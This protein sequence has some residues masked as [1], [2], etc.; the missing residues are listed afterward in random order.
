M[1]FST[2]ARVLENEF[3]DRRRII[4]TVGVVL[5]PLLNDEFHGTSQP[6]IAFL[7]HDRILFE[8][9]HFVRVAAHVQQRNLRIGQGFQVVKGILVIGEGLRFG[10]KMVTLKQRLPI[11][12]I[13]MNKIQLVE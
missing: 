4:K 7:E 9:D 1:F 2:K 10:F 13:W 5:E 12:I 11:V 8:R 6:L 3:H